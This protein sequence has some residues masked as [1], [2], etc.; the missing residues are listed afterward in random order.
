MLMLF[1]GIMGARKWVES[2]HKLTT[3][4]WP[5]YSQHSWK[6]PSHESEYLKKFE[7]QIKEVRIEIYIVL[8]RNIRKFACFRF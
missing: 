8:R 1:Q 5:S 2:C 7:I 4:F 6:G 3:L